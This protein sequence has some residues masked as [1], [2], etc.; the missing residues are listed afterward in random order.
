M[1]FATLCYG[2]KFI[3]KHEKEINKVGQ[4]NTV[5][6]LTDQPDRFP[7]CITYDYSEFT[8]KKV[9]SYYSKINFLFYLVKK[10]KTRVNYIDADFLRTSFNKSIIKDDTTLFCS[11]IIAPE[12]ILLNDLQRDA[13]FKNYYRFLSNHGLDPTTTCYIT[14]AFISFPYRED[15]NDIIILSNKLQFDIES[16]F[17]GE[18]KK[19]Y[20]TRIKKYAK[21]GIGFAE[22]SA[23]SVIAYRFNIYFKG[24]KSNRDLN[25]TNS[26]L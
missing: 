22:G 9:F 18:D 14:E 10:L 19:F 13:H 15:I 3:S 4:S 23:L 25:L 26:L 17:N 11:V 5:Y 21:T 1:I 20:G 2:D 16:I 7:F 12:N 6:V 24:V 8:N